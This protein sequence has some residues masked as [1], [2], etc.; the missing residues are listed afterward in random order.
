VICIPKINKISPYLYLHCLPFLP[1]KFNSN[2]NLREISLHFETFN[3]SLKYFTALSYSEVHAL[4]SV[5][6]NANL[7][8]YYKNFNY[9]WKYIRKFMKYYDST[10]FFNFLVTLIFLQWL[11]L[12]RKNVFEASFRH[13]LFVLN[14]ISNFN[15]NILKI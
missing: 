8:I 1:G 5:I 3:T 14:T 15:L 6:F 11:S 13:I 2:S 9:F 7:F 10:F 4:L 12:H